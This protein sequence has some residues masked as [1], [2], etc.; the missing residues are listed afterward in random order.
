[1]AKKKVP[2]IRQSWLGW[3][4][5]A[6]GTLAG[7]SQMIW[8][9]PDEINEQ[10]DLFGKVTGQQPLNEHDWRNAITWSA[11][12]SL[13]LS[14][15]HSMKALAI[16]ASPN[17]EC[18][19]THDLE[20]LWEDLQPVDKQ[21]VA[22]SAQQFKNIPKDTKLGQG[23]HPTSVEELA[24]IARHHK[25]TFEHS[26]YYLETQK[27]EISQDL[28]KN[29]ELWKFALALLIYAKRLLYTT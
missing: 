24:E 29:V 21:G 6:E 7:A 16:R 5:M 18:R 15:E 19:K 17:G 8:Q 11:S 2:L 12:V 20:C 27:E 14:A 10:R 1:M 4:N 25:D 3:L 23:S 9:S 28:T 26:R 13:A 22:E